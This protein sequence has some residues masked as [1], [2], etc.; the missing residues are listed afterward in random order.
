MSSAKHARDEGGDSK[1]VLIDTPRCKERGR[2]AE[3]ADVTRCAEAA[4]SE[5]VT[6]ATHAWNSRERILVKRMEEYFVE[7]GEEILVEVG[8]LEA[9]VLCPTDVAGV[10]DE[11]AK[12]ACDQEGR[13]KFVFIKTKEGNL[14][15]DVKRY[16]I[17]RARIDADCQELR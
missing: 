4:R 14:V 7:K 3:V 11:L 12:K 6:D 2:G 17:Y 5:K 8:T 1:F 10:M 15:A 16:A 13:R 9:Y